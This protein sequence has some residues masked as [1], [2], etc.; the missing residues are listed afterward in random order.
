MG[1]G[2]ITLPIIDAAVAYDYPITNQTFILVARNV[3]YV[4]AMDHNLILPC[5]MRE[6]WLTVNDTPMIHIKEPTLLDH[7]IICDESDL[8]IRL[9]FHGILSCFKTRA[10]TSEEILDPDSTI[11]IL[12]P[13]GTSWDPH[14]ILIVTC[15]G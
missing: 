12:S 14:G 15:I 8:H 2:T 6:A 4:P 5:V 3:L 11:I 1:V 13:D 9:H 7:A 10:Q